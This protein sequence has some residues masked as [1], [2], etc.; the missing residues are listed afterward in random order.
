MKHDTNMEMA[1]KVLREAK[2][3]LELARMLYKTRLEG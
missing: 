1:T 3:K 2:V